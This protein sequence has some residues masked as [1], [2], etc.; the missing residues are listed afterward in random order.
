MPKT[1]KLCENL[2]GET[3]VVISGITSSMYQK[4]LEHLIKKNTT[5]T[6]GSDDWVPLIFSFLLGDNVSSEYDVKII[7]LHDKY[8]DLDI[9][10]D[11]VHIGHTKDTS[12][13]YEDIAKGVLRNLN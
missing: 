13:Y 1:L 2:K 11:L 7:D 8:S 4:T 12:V 5:V 6:S 9:W 10:L 3:L